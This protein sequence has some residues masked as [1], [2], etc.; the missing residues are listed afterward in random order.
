MV[1]VGEYTIHGILYEWIL[2]KPYKRQ[3]SIKPEEPPI[4]GLIFYF[5]SENSPWFLLKNFRLTTWFLQGAQKNNRPR[6]GSPVFLGGFQIPPVC[7]PHSDISTLAPGQVRGCRTGKVSSW[8]HLLNL[9][10]SENRGTPKSSILIGISIINHPCWGTPI[11]GNTHLDFEGPQVDV[12]QKWVRN[13]LDA[14]WKWQEGCFFKVKWS[15]NYDVCPVF[16]SL[17]R[18]SVWGQ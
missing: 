8:V 14:L 7:N 5:A 18:C 2:F 10:V 6:K 11:F 1:N 9:G 15:L 16:C 3:L 12:L 4:F 13:D 17:K